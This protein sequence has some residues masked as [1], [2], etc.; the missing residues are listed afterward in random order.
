M[1]QPFLAVLISQ[2][3]LSV[4]KAVAHLRKDFPR[5]Q[6]MRAAKGETV[7]QQHP[8][9]GNVRRAYGSREFFPANVVCG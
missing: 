8:P 1:G 3:E 4:V 6:E 5:I 2:L 7:V 9:V